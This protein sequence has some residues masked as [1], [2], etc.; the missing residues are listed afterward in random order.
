MPVI[1]EFYA[2]T[3]TQVYHVKD[4]MSTD[5]PAPVARKIALI[6]KSD[7]QVGSVL[8]NGTMLAITTRLQ[9]YVPEG[10]GIT[11]FERRIEKVNTGYWGGHS[12][13]IV[14]LFRSRRKATQCLGSGKLVPSD[15]RWLEETKKILSEIP[16]DHPTIYVCRH[17]GM[18][19]LKL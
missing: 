12:S 11:S 18:T 2:V 7:V 10:G 8:A 1:R 19:L 17:E 5:D 15:P 14:A 13:D 16:D 3:E 4:H 9:M 6:G